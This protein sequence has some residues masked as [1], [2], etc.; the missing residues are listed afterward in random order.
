MTFD[1]TITAAL[2]RKETGLR[3]ALGMVLG[4]GFQQ[5]LTHLEVTREIAYGQLPG[6]PTVGVTGHASKP[7]GSLLKGLERGYSARR[8]EDCDQERQITRQ[9]NTAHA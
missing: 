5:A 7:H 3:P 8:N 6:F 9:R 2:L 1:P 4:S